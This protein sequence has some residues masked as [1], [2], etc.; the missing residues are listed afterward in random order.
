[1]GD[2]G[3]AIITAGGLRRRCDRLGCATVNAALIRTLRGSGGLE[4]PQRERSGLLES[5]APP[6]RRGVLY[7]AESL[8][9]AISPPGATFPTVGVVSILPGHA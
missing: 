9:T 5:F 1:M 6:L 7:P 4:D 8:G 2:H 3:G